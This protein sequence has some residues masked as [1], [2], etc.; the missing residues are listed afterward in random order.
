M[1]YVHYK[2]APAE[3]NELEKYIKFLAF[4]TTQ[5]ICQSR[6]GDK[7]ES[8]CVADVNGRNYWVSLTPNN[9]L[10]SSRFIFLRCISSCHCYLYSV[11]AALIPVFCLHYLTQPWRLHSLS[12]IYNRNFLFFYSHHCTQPNILLQCINNVVCI[13]AR[14]IRW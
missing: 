5:V 4:K 12:Q 8:K 9:I 13:C 3:K 7:H 10:S 11:P 6:Q 2:L 1:A 14:E